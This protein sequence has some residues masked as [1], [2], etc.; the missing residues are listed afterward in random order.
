VF[1]LNLN[2]AC[3]SSVVLLELVRIT[4]LMLRSEENSF[5]VFSGSRPNLRTFSKTRRWPQ[6]F[7]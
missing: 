7:V 2:Y 6:D 5:P 3:K 4:E 1:S